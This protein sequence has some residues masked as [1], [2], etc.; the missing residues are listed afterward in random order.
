ME[1]YTTNDLC[2]LLKVNRS[3][4]QWL[5]DSQLLKARK[6][7]KGFITTEDELKEFMALTA[8][9]DL[10]SKKKI[11]IVGMN[12]KRIGILNLTNGIADSTKAKI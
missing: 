5:R 12:I 3:K 2:K 10:S 4:I 7:G 6:L 9:L 8:G 11:E 1:I